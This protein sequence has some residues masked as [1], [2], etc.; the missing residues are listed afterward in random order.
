[1]RTK[2]GKRELE[3]EVTRRRA[4]A[5]ENLHAREELVVA[6]ENKMKEAQ[7]AVKKWTRIKQ[8]IQA[9]ATYESND[10]DDAIRNITM[11]EERIVRCANRAE[12]LRETVVKLNEDLKKELKDRKIATIEDVY[13]KYCALHYLETVHVCRKLCAH[14][15]LR[16]PWDGNEGELYEKW[17]RSYAFNDASIDKDMSLERALD[18]ATE[19]HLAKRHTE[20]GT[21]YN[22]DD[23]DDMTK[24]DVE[25]YVRYKNSKKK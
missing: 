24:Y 6:E 12:A 21:E 4:S 25:L 11:E 1:M 19:A 20:D 14:R 15:K 8:S 2:E 3:K 23:T 16:R 17:L 9:K 22:W 5:F 10:L 13:T 18:Q 7:E